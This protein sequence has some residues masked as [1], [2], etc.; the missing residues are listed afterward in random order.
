MNRKE[1]YK[2]K[3]KYRQT[4]NRQ[5]RRYYGKTKDA[6][7]TGKPWT[8]EELAIIIDHQITDTEISSIIGRSVGAIQ[9]MRHKYKKK[10]NL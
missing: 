5:K 7:N 4:R 2:D 1:N 3:E 9:G 6:P 8:E 10:H